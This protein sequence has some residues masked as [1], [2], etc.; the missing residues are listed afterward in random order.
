MEASMKTWKIVSAVLAV[1][2][3]AWSGTALAQSKAGKCGS[4]PEK[5]EGQVV[6][7]DVEQGKVVVRGT[8]GVTH[9]FQAGKETLQD[10]KVGD[11]LEAKLRSV[12]ECK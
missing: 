5:L 1:A 6:K 11:R 2:V 12:P 7:I 3:V 9:E 4:T 10:Y 8:D